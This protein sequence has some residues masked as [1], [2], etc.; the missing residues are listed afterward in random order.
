[1]Q[2]T[3]Y[4]AT[5][6]NDGYRVQPRLLK[7]IREPSEDGQTFGPLLEEVSP[8]ILNKTSNTQEEIDRVKQGLRQVYVGSRDCTF[9]F[10]KYSIYCCR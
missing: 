10:S 1:M 7:E 6:A 9:K 5:I 8:N 4:I 3:Q 2:L